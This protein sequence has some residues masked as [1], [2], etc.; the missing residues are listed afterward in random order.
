MTV[1]L[2][3][4]FFKLII[5]CVK[6]FL[7]GPRVFLVHWREI[8]LQFYN[9][10][11]ISKSTGIWTG[12]CAGANCGSGL[13]KWVREPHPLAQFNRSTGPTWPTI[14][15]IHD[16]LISLSLSLSLSLSPLSLFISPLLSLSLFFQFFL[17][18][19]QT[20]TVEL[21]HWRHKE[22]KKKI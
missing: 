17:F 11:N 7:C 5:K 2:L 21:W 1:R 18:M 19:F 10:T 13:S 9:I 12:S 4:F 6:Y 22:N 14:S 15:I 20:N 3:F 8:K 16:P